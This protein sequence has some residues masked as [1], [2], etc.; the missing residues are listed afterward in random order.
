MRHA[1]ESIRPSDAINLAFISFL[2]LVSIAFRGRVQDWSLLAPLYLLL[3]VAAFF[4][5]YVDCKRPG[6]FI[7]FL[8]RWYPLAYI[9]ISYFSLGK[10]VHHVL[11]YDIDAQLIAIDYAIFGVH[12]TVFLTRF[13]NPFIVDLLELCYASFYWLPVILGL[14]L[15]AKQRMQEFETLATAISLGFYLSY[16]GNLIFPVQGPYYTLDALH[17]VPV[18]GSWLGNFLRSFLFSLEPYKWDCFPSGHTAVTLIVI[19]Y[20]YRFARRLFWVMLPVTVGLIISTVFLQH[21]YV[22][23]IIAGVTVAGVV[24]FA[25]DLIQRAWPDRVKKSS[26]IDQSESSGSI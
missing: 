20:C 6:R 15:Y 4:L 7:G 11:P 2:L 21:H 24:V 23:D 26:S 10:I 13:M 18:E 14:V 22:V 1:L 25:T 16:I 9:G 17:T 3:L 5:L 12:P 8:R 19:V